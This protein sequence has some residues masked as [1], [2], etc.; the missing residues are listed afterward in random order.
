VKISE[1]RKIKCV[2]LIF[3]FFCLLILLLLYFRCVIALFVRLFDA[4]LF[5]CLLDAVCIQCQFLCF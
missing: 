4:F 1:V 3:V 5:V 2:F